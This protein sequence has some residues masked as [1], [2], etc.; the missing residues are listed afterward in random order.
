MKKEITYNLEESNS[1]I[2]LTK[3]ELQCLMYLSQGL[4]TKEVARHMYI[5]DGTVISH[6]RS[7]RRK[8]DSRNITQAVTKAYKSGLL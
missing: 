4:N 3:R 7:I 1:P 6:T 2:R 8:L 5:S